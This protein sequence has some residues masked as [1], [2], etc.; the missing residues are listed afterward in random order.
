MSLPGGEGTLG[1]G[2]AG[3]GRR[4]AGARGGCGSAGA[5]GGHGQLEE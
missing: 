4:S 5:R 2:S 3:G 1:C